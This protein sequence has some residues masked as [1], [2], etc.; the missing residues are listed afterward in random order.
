MRL[1][2]ESCRAAVTV[3]NSACTQSQQVCK[4]LI[5]EAYNLHETYTV[6]IV[7]DCMNPLLEW[8]RR[9]SMSEA[10][11]NWLRG[12]LESAA[13]IFGIALQRLRNVALHCIALCNV[14]VVLM[15]EPPC[16]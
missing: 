14:M 4:V 16:S 13:A 2:V 12:G 5:T 6:V 8:L 10:G 3:E 7:R 11:D 15:S 1:T 9:R